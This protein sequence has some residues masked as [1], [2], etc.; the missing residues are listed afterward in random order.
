MICS[1][2][3]G[4]LTKNEMSLVAF[5]TASERFRF[6]PDAKERNT[7][8]VIKDDSLMTTRASTSADTVDDAAQ[9]GVISSVIK[10]GE[11]PSKEYL[12]DLLSCSI[13]CTKSV[14]TEDYAIGNPTELAVLKGAHKAG[15][16]C[17]SF[18][19]ELPCIA[20]VPFS[21]EYK[22]MA[23][24]HDMKQLCCFLKIY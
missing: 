3:T 21:S 7:D 16:D 6:D 23:A 9:S 12:H 15:I 8:S 17:N 11:H 18:K 14:L 10:K 19:K 13:L 4:T 1:D 20:E 24:V 22:F 2:K 5:V